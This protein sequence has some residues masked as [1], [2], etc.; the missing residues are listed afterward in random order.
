MP[1]K[2]IQKNLS[3]VFWFDILTFMEEGEKDKRTTCE[4]I[5]FVF[6]F[7]SNSRQDILQYA[8]DSFYEVQLNLI[9]LTLEQ[10]AV[11]TETWLKRNEQVWRKRNREGDMQRGVET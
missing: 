4:Q 9:K 2:I 5:F 7:Q 10:I 1:S 3:A 11:K 8:N 6:M